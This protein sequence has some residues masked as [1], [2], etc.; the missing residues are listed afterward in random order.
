MTHLNRVLPPDPRVPARTASFRLNRADSNAAA[1]PA[2]PAV[3][4]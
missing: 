2:A 1:A 3:A 4:D